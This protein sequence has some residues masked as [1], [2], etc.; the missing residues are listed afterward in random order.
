MHFFIFLTAHWYLSLFFQSF[1][2][3]RYAA[4]QQFSMGRGWEKFFFV[5]CFITQGSSYISAYAYALMHRL[6]HEHADTDKDPH[7][8]YYA[9]GVFKTLLQTRNSYAA[10]FSGKTMVPDKYK[11][12]IPRWDRFDHF[13]HNWIT[14]LCWIAVYIAIYARLA[15]H[16]W[17]Y[18]F[19]PFTIMICSVQGFAVN[20]WAHK[21]GYSNKAGN[22]HSKNILPL[23]L[24]F[25][26]E[27]YHSNHHYYPGRAN[28]GIRWFEID[29]GYYVIRIFDKLNVIRLKQ[30]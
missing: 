26:G 25:W 19:L 8:P 5:C 9:K 17:M 18:L 24:I 14:R 13:A 11:K 6:H 21:F 12:D 28:Y 10:I 27:A 7:S 2:H 1:F 20:W 23:D 30:T 15:T 4:H 16:W 3:H 22:D 29:P